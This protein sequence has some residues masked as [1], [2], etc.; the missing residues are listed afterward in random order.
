MHRGPHSGNSSDWP[1]VLPLTVDLVLRATCCCSRAHQNQGK[2]GGTCPVLTILTFPHRA[3]TLCT[4]T[5]GGCC[6]HDG[7]GFWSD[8]SASCG[9][10][11]LSGRWRCQNWSTHMREC[12]PMRWI[13]TCGWMPWVPA[14][15]SASLIGWAFLSPY[16]PFNTKFNFRETV[17][18]M[19]RFLL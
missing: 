7:F 15:G 8:I 18:F 4:W 14:R 5:C 12:V 9:W 1:D 13:P 2:V 16:S 11:R 10:T 6:T 3:S 17:W 19:T